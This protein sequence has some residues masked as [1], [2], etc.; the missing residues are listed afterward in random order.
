MTTPQTLTAAD[1][2]HEAHIKSLGEKMKA[3][4]EKWAFIW[5]RGAQA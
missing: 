5:E 3:A 2:A 4:Y 1:A